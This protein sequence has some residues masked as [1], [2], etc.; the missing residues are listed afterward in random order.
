MLPPWDRAK[1]IT[2]KAYEFQYDGGNVM[3]NHISEQQFLALGNLSNIDVL[4]EGLYCYDSTVFTL[5]PAMQNRISDNLTRKIKQFINSIPAVPKAI[6]YLQSKAECI[7]RFDMIPEEIKRALQNGT[8]EVVP[9]K[10]SADAFFLQ[11]RSTVKDLMIN[12]RV[13]GKSRKI[14]DIPL[15]IRNIPV[16][17]AGAI[18]CLSMQ[19]QLNQIC[20]GLREISETCERNFARI[21]RG[22]RDDRLAKLFSSRSNFI[23]ALAMS[24]E[25]LQRQMLMQAIYDANS[26][27]AKL[28][29]Q[30]KS[31]TSLLSGEKS[32]KSED[33]ANMVR[34]INIA[35]VAMNNAVQISLYSYQVLGE[36]SAQL[37]VVKEHET[38][39][40][41]VLLEEIKVGDKKISVWEKI[42]SSGKSRATPDSFRQLPS[43]LINNSVAFIEGTNKNQ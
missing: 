31:D 37:A 11:I 9:C 5:T 3:E 2:R 33:M 38:F 28:A 8:A 1:M 39:V 18:Q 43:R 17:I 42:Q 15:D 16:D 7:P 21:I 4:D 6:D 40:R 34:D 10:N 30:I 24:D 20:N 23:Q 19:T 41:Q 25:S 35:I 29:F 22:Q 14:G 13:Y 12:G 26:A 32:L 27:H 36:R